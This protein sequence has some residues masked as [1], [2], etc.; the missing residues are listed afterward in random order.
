MQRKSH[1]MAEAV[2]STATG[3]LLS[4]AIQIYLLPLY[5]VHLTIQSNLQII[6]VFTVAS[7]LRQYVLRRVFNRI[8][9]KE[10]AVL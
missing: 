9:A 3:F 7:L 10:W 1:S 4:L 6:T 2:T 5:G 8:T